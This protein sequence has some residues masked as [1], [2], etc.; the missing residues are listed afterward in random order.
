MLKLSLKNKYISTVNPHRT[1]L[2]CIL[3]CTGHQSE[4]ILQTDYPPIT[5]NVEESLPKCLV[6]TERQL[7]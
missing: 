4:P 1:L 7:P 5:H 2:T 6:T 3:R